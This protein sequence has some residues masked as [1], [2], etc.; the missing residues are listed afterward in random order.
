MVFLCLNL[1][2]SLFPADNWVYFLC[3]AILCAMAQSFSFLSLC[4]LRVKWI[5]PMMV[6]KFMYQ[7]KIPY[8]FMFLKGHFIFGDEIDI[9][10][11]TRKG[12]FHPDTCWMLHTL[13]SVFYS[14][15]TSPAL[16]PLSAVQPTIWQGLGCVG[17]LQCTLSL[18]CASTP[19][20]SPR[21]GSPAVFYLFLC[22][23]SISCPPSSFSNCS[24][25]MLYLPSYIASMPP[26]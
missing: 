7:R 17:P 21:L 16:Q 11:Q 1:S 5:Q 22:L 8:R 23:V 9:G 14:V 24:Y 26:S 18:L 6:I 19:T 20:P 4:F 12:P 10:K 15:L 3:G 13:P 25:R 2:F